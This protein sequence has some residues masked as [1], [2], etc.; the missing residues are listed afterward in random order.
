MWSILELADLNKTCEHAIDVTKF[1]LNHHK[2]PD[3]FSTNFIWTVRM[4]VPDSPL[5]QIVAAQD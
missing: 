5:P 4:P 2:M 3:V 1:F